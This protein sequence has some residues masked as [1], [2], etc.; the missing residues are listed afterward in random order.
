MGN[1]QEINFTPFLYQIYDN[2]YRNITASTS[3]VIRADSFIFYKS[4]MPEHN[5]AIHFTAKTSASHAIRTDNQK[6]R[7][8]FGLRRLLALGFIC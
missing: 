2:G 8:P 3:L 5:R 1:L 4:S 6:R 7:N